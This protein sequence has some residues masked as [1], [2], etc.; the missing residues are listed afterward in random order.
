MP[1]ARQVQIHRHSTFPKLRP[2]PSG[3]CHLIAKWSALSECGS[4][5]PPSHPQPSLYPSQ[6]SREV[7]R[8]L[9]S[10]GQRAADTL[11]PGCPTSC[12]Y[13]A[14]MNDSRQRQSF[15]NSPHRLRITPAAAEPQKPTSSL[16]P[17]PHCPSAAKP[18]VPTST[19]PETPRTR[20]ARFPA[21]LFFSLFPL[22]RPFHSGTPETTANDRKPPPTTANSLTAPSTVPAP[23]T[24]AAPA[25]STPRS[26]TDTA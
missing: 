7:R 21:P 25:N 5:C 3:P 19:R 22:F 1:P 16:L 12:G 15:T 10:V 11:I 14:T 23:E 8:T 9:L 4:Q 20:R 17:P 13:M 6:T 2:T 18:N 26:T 24:H